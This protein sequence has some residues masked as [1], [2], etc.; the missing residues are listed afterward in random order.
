MA[1]PISRPTRLSCLNRPMYLPSPPVSVAAP[2]SGN[3]P[4]VA[5]VHSCRQAGPGTSSTARAGLLRSALRAYRALTY[6]IAHSLIRP[7]RSAGGGD[8]GLSRTAPDARHKGCQ[9]HHDTH[10]HL[11]CRHPLILSTLIL[12]TLKGCQGH[13]DRP[14]SCAREAPARAASPRPRQVP[15]VCDSSLPA[16]SDPG[17][18]ASDGW[19]CLRLVSLTAET[20][21][22]SPAPARVSLRS[23]AVRSRC[24]ASAATRKRSLHARDTS[25][26]GP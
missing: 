26:R 18:A 15:S 6:L 16:A 5:G 19:L 8:C 25:W 3:R 9:G 24:R 7:A 1:S 17:P 2:G 4:A 11:S 13:H 12:S 21:L 20:R 10:T 14:C 23:S 22:V